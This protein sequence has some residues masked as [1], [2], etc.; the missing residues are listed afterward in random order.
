MNAFTKTLLAT[1][2]ASI[3][4]AP[5]AASAE[6]RSHRIKLAMTAP[7][8][9]AL[10]DAGLK[11]AELVRE[12][13]DGKMKITVF[14]GGKLGG[15]LQVIGSL[16][17]GT[18]EM[19]LTN[20]S[21]LQSLVKEMTV[22][23][24]PFLFANEEEAD[25][26]VDGPVGKKLLDLLPEYGIVGLAYMELGLRHVTNS[27]RP[28]TKLEDLQGLKLR[29]LQTPIYIDFINALGANA[30][31]L[32]YPEVFSALETKTVDGATNTVT[33]VQAQKFDE[34]QKY[35]SLTHHMYNPSLLFVSKKFW[36]GLNAEERQLLQEAADQVRDFERKLSREKTATA[37]AELAKTMEINEVTPEERAR[38][39]E[40]AK[41]VI[42]KYTAQ[43][44]ASLVQEIEAEIAKSGGGS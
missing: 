7:Q 18:I 16:Q 11:L 4:L 36:D 14:E 24:L 8:G 19:D 17:G 32:P 27:K 25:A 22:Y 12:Q 29:I 38:M 44:G 41:P 23:D 6:I 1:V 20:A 9:S 10:Y 30:T 28:I 42:D 33:L 39:R 40:Q 37:L 26:V 21:F 3:A 15:D 2:V 34:V 31:P 43:V 13:S 35:L 5:I